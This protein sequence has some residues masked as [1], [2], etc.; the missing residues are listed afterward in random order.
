MRSNS[1]DILRISTGLFVALG[2]LQSQQCTN[3]RAAGSAAVNLRVCD[4]K[5]V[6]LLISFLA[7]KIRAYMIR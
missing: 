1:F 5:V 4:L 2:A 7:A 6:K 3:Y